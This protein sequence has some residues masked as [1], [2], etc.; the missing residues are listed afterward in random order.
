ML[1]I[2]SDFRYFTSPERQSTEW[3]PAARM[4]KKVNLLGGEDVAHKDALVVGVVM[5]PELP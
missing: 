2:A 4:R 1:I 5:P 3:P